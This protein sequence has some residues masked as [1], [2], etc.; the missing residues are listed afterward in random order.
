M[1]EQLFGPKWPM[2]FW[3]KSREKGPRRP[4][5]SKLARAAREHKLGVPRGGI[6]SDSFRNMAIQRNLARRANK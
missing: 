6:V 1:F 4:A 2:N 3:G 5:G